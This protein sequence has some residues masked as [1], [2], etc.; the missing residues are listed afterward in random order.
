ML[1]ER[2]ATKR[3]SKSREVRRDR[4]IE[5]HRSVRVVASPVRGRT[6]NRV[7]FP[8]PLTFPG[9]S[10]ASRV[11]NARR[12]CRVRR[13]TIVSASIDGLSRSRSTR[14]P[15]STPVV[16]RVVSPC[17]SQSSVRPRETQFA[18]STSVPNAVQHSRRRGASSS[19]QLSIVGSSRR[20]DRYR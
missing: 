20:T 6:V 1:I 18:R 10:S 15:Q 3:V 16:S 14:I 2:R 8:R 9:A 12:E 17:S 19:I 13:R 4:S 7:A 11:L 5:S